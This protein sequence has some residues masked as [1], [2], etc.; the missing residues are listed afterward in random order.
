MIIYTCSVIRGYKR[1]GLGLIHVSSLQTEP[2]FSNM[3]FSTEN[4]TFEFKFE[5]IPFFSG[6][7]SVPL[8]N[9]ALR[10]QNI[11]NLKKPGIS[12][13]QA[14]QNMCANI[15]LTCTWKG[16]ANLINAFP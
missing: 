2:N 6:V 1:S 3:T 9:L 8:F 11:K 5:S 4:R 13:V 16:M 15:K 7:E 14:S 10:S 12:N